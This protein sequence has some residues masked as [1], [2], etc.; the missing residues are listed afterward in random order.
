MSKYRVPIK[1]MSAQCQRIYKFIEK[2][3]SI[4]PMQALNECAVMRL[5]ARICDLE[6]AGYEFRHEMVDAVNRFGEKVRF[7][8][9]RL[10]A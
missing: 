2:N 1:A 5:A 8:E 7:M 10:V 4:N 6:F 3:G 9:Y